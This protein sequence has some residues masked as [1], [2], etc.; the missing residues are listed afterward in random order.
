VAA[1]VGAEGMQDSDQLILEAAE[2]IRLEFLCQNSYSDD[3]FST[4]ELTAE[5]IGEIIGWTDETESKLAACE[6]LESI[7]RRPKT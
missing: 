1:I 3:A 6:P 5:K 7:I 2:R 4:P